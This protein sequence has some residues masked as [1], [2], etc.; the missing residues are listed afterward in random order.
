MLCQGTS[1]LAKY[2]VS[3]HQHTQNQFP[4]AFFLTL[5][6]WNIRNAP[7]VLDTTKKRLGVNA[8]LFFFSC[9]QEHGP[10]AWLQT[11]GKKGS[12]HGNCKLQPNCL[13]LSFS[14]S[15]SLSLSF[16]LTLS[17]SLSLSLSLSHFPSPSL[18]HSQCFSSFFFSLA[19]N[20]THISLYTKDQGR[21][22]KVIWRYLNSRHDFVSIEHDFLILAWSTGMSK[23]ILNMK[24][25]GWNA[26]H[27]KYNS[28]WHIGAHESIRL[29]TRKCVKGFK[30]YSISTGESSS[31]V[32]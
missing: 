12:F 16:S 9:C 17:F 30:L 29:G 8:T 15:L 6:F 18:C 27:L 21:Q 24:N 19:T 5:T 32:L 10:Q 20:Q 14:L 13:T 1:Y 4:P 2:N 25:N 31:L 28:H 22:M 23:A 3:Q 26:P 11:E 7:R